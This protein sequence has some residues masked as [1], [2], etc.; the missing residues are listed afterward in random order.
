[1]AHTHRHTRTHTHTHAHRHTHAHTHA[2]THFT[3][4]SCVLLHDTGEPVQ[5]YKRHAQLRVAKGSYWD[6]IAGVLNWF[7]AVLPVFNPHTV[8]RRA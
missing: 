2:G 7:N 6:Q 4:N 5:K 1:M 8:W 3:F